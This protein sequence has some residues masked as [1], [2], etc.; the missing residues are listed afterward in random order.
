MK[1]AASEIAPFPGCVELASERLGGRALAASD[2]FFAPKENL[3]KPGRGV[4]LP[5]K[6]GGLR[7]TC[8]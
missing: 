3:L 1:P 6:L 8:R 4:F 5:G 7:K 2:D